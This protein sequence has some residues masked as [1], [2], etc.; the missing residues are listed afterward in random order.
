MT[1]ALNDSRPKTSAS[2]DPAAV[3]RAFAQ[4]TETGTD[5]DRVDVVVDPAL[6][7]PMRYSANLLF[8][9]GHSVRA[10]SLAPE[11]ILGS[12]SAQDR[13]VLASALLKEGSHQLMAGWLWFAGTV[14]HEGVRTQYCF[15]AISVPVAAK[16]TMLSLGDV[17][18]SPQV[19]ASVTRLITDPVYR[20]DLFGRR[21]F[22]GGALTD[23]YL[24]G[25]DAPEY[26]PVDTRVIPRLDRLRSW[27][28]EIAAELGFVIAERSAVHEANPAERR[29]RDGVG[30]IIGSFLYVDQPTEYQTTSESLIALSK[31][32][33]LPTTAFSKIYGTAQTAVG[34]LDDVAQLRPMSVRQ[35][36]IA[37][38]V[39]A[40]ELSVLSGPPGTGKTHLV[41][42]IAHEALARGKSVL[43]AAS[44]DHSVDVLVE[45]FSNSPGPTPVVFGDSP[46]SHDLSQRLRDHGSWVPLP[47]LDGVV[48]KPKA[49][50]GHERLA[51]E[52]SSALAGD[53][54][55]VRML[56]DP[57]ERARSV[58]VLDEVGDLDR[59]ARLLEASRAD[60]STARIR[61]VLS[62]R[63]RKRML[64]AGDQK[65]RLAELFALRSGEQVIVNGGL[66]LDDTINALAESEQEAEN[67]RGELITMGWL[68]GLNR[69]ER[70]ALSKVASAVAARGNKRR[71]SFRSEPAM[72]F[73]RAAPLWVGSIQ[74]IDEVL[75]R[76]AGMFDLVILDEASQI[77]QINAA[78][79]LIRA[80]AAIVCGD[81][82]QLG[83]A[84]FVSNERVERAAADNSLTIG[85]LN[86]RRASIHDAVAAIAPTRV[87]D[88][89]FRSVPHLVEFSAR[90]FYNSSLHTVTRH[91]S[92]EDASYIDVSVVAGRR[93]TS[94]VNDA[95]VARCMTV[96]DDLVR[97][98]WDSIG[99]MS[100]F[101]SQADALEKAVLSRFSLEDIERFGL[102]VGTAHGFQGSERRV[103]IMSWAI[104][105]DEGAKPWQ[106]VNQPNLFN[107]M[108]T[109]AQERVVVVTSM[110]Q[111]PGL[112]GDYVRWSEPLTTRVE[113][114][115]PFNP[116]VEQIVRALRSAGVTIRTN[117]AVGR[118]SI[119][120]VAGAAGNAVAI[121]C[122][123]HVD[124]AAAHIDRAMQLRRMGWRTTDAY[125]SKWRH[126]V[127]DFVADFEQRFPNVG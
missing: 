72:V 21:E 24:G 74:D 105:P 53:A 32:N 25:G 65:V 27:A 107:V 113:S 16:S 18:I 31:L 51:E 61:A 95:E 35:R 126:R 67:A 33:G 108:V 13:G 48:E 98:G 45:H 6:I 23:E 79:A 56:A 100:P 12:I 96:V 30:L 40:D 22:G 62:S 110:A 38:Q 57:A 49:I 66:S 34:A 47:G 115:D 104:G 41:T 55:A 5:K 97:T 14:E 86:A 77:D 68:D 116:W 101:R 112:A 26:V 28:D 121:D 75:P 43:V 106:F 94:G 90:R 46:R 87:L 118:Y 8:Q 70:A 91:P 99:L 64:G 120:V 17:S 2:A 76:T 63:R 89:H 73:T 92:N 127:S 54:A 78:N 69:R 52:I 83:H 85:Q 3:L 4:L 10:W 111:P 119:D 109:R 7:T 58:D 124:G 11:G 1:D 81:P 84:S 20:D 93:D 50:A 9:T 80:K 39:L 60:G 82:R 15:P 44:S 29:H 117:Y 19:E 59:L 88:E 42:V 37:T 125:E 122:V 114:G 103:V 102:R 123:P 71:R 36:E